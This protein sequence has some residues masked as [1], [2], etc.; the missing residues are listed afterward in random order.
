M[1]F[2][3]TKIWVKGDADISHI[4]I[5]K[6]KSQA[7]FLTGKI[8][9]RFVKPTLPVSAIRIPQ[10]YLRVTLTGGHTCGAGNTCLYLGP[11]GA[12]C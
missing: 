12:D 5:N 2:G 4:Q 11:E 8:T 1:E 3:G 9:Q 7:K 6:I 10:P